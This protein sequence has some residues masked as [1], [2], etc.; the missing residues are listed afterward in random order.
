MSESEETLTIEAICLA[1]EC[2]VLQ[3]FS[4]SVA[5][6]DL[7]T[8]KLDLDES[9]VLALPF[10]LIA[11]ADV[12]VAAKTSGK[13]MASVL[14]MIFSDREGRGEEAAHHHGSWY[15]STLSAD[16]Q[17]SCRLLSEHVE[18][19][20]AVEWRRILAVANQ[21]QQQG[22]LDQET[23]ESLGLHFAGRPTVH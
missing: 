17:K 3:A 2:V 11:L 23:L 16:F 8:G 21:I 20:I 12:A 6:V 13:E 15:A 1:A 10:H 9:S 18:K 7:A 19:L 4:V 14:E 5:G 22:E